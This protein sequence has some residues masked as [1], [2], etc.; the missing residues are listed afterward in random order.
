MRLL[1]VKLLYAFCSPLVWLFMWMN[2]VIFKPNVYFC[3]IPIIS[4]KRGSFF[5]IGARNRFVST[6]ICNLIG[7]NHRCVMSTNSSDSILI[8]GER[9]SFSGVSIRCFKSIS[10]GNDVRM[11]ANCV[12]LDG[13][14]HQN[15]FRT[16][17]NRPVVIGDH[18][19][20]G[21][22]VTVMKGV[23]IG[24]NSLIGMG[25]VVTKDIPANVVAAGNP[26]RVIREIQK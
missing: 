9:C 16:R 12:I 8:I 15:D 10:I 11:G 24:E 13:D 7:I 26:C 19:W 18:V 17:E 3:G 5:K 22:N 25:S 1:I 6:S 23:T 20:L 4:R 14:G 21:A 2:R